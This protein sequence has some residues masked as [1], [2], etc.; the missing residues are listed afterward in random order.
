[1]V[2]VYKPSRT[3]PSQTLD[4]GFWRTFCRQEV[5]PPGPA[6]RAEGGRVSA[7]CVGQ[8]DGSGSEHGRERRHCTVT[9]SP[10]WKHKQMGVGMGQL[11]LNVRCQRISAQEMT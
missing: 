10:S 1:M 8:R 4:L 2:M 11:F 7:V 5:W 6:G 3:E 9:H